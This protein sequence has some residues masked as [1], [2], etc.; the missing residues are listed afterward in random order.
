[1]RAPPFGHE[2]QFAEAFFD[3]VVRYKIDLRY[4]FVLIFGGTVFEIWMGGADDSSLG[5]FIVFFDIQFCN[6]C[7]QQMPKNGS[8]Q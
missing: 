6:Q 8:S 4:S 5:I 2:Q 3:D 7:C 1:V